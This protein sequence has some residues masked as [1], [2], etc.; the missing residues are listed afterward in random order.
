MDVI[1]INVPF[2]GAELFL[3]DHQGQ[4]Y[5]PMKPIVEGMGM[6]WG[7]QF[8]KLKQRF[9]STI[10]E[11]TI[12]AS[13]GKERLMTCL[14]VRKLFGWLMTISANKV[15]P[16]LRDTILM[17][18]NEC[19][20]VLWDY[21]TKGHAINSRKTITP[22]QQAEL[23]AIVENRGQDNR[24][25]YAEMWS[26]HNRHFKIAKY[27]QLLQVHF[28][29]SKAYL[30]NMD[31]KAKSLPAPVVTID[32]VQLRLASEVSLLMTSQLVPLLAQSEGKTAH[33]FLVSIDTLA[34]TVYARP[35]T[36]EE[37]VVNAVEIM[38][39]HSSFSMLLRRLGL[40]ECAAFA[41]LAKK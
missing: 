27:S 9:A 40:V 38:E 17:Y 41:K 31:L 2:H 3:V 16:E 10:V 24:G 21:W 4:P 33:R 18:Q 25:V 12:V 37:V 6:D 35:M 20:D 13:D 39:G 19:D 28:D 15:Q 34:N 8:R 22:E 7:T 29:E 5:T 14:P 30:Q 23:H 26:R 1:Q 11:M 36:Q 32:P